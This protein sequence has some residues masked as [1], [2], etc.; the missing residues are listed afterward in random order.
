MT[1]FLMFQLPNVVGF[2]FGIVQMIIYFMYMNRK[3]VGSEAKNQ[4]EANDSLPKDTDPEI[5]LND[6]NESNYR[7][8][9]QKCKCQCAMPEA[10]NAESLA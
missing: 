3:K 6:G 5:E 2:T 9:I 1:P 4:E 10:E 8:I 7:S